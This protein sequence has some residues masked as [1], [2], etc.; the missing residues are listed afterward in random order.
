MSG[1]PS[2]EI[3][4]AELE[5]RFA[6]LA[7]GDTGTRERVLRAMARTTPVLARRLAALLDAHLHH[8][9]EVERVGAEARSALGL[10]DADALVGR[11]LDGWRLTELLGRGGM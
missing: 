11:E 2:G 1:R 8:A 10:F 7:A 5:R 9:D 4:P 6:E 3:D